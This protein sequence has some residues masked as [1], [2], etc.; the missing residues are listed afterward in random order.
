MAFHNRSVIEE[1]IHHK[2]MLPK[3]QLQLCDYIL[4]N[5]Q[6]MGL[7]TVKEL[8]DNADVGISTVMRL[9]H[10]LG[11]HTFNDFRRDIFNESYPY[12]SKWTLRKSFTEETG[13]T[14]HHSTVV[15]IWKGSIDILEQS[16]DDELIVH[17]EKAVDVICQSSQ[18][19][20][21]GTRPYKSLALYLEQM[22]NEFYPKIKQLS[23]DT[24]T[25][26]DK[27]L[28]ADKEEALLVF[29]FE[30]Y[31]NRVV[32][33]AELA[34]R[35]GMKIILVTDYMACPIIQYA[36]V[37]L[38]VQTSK[39]QYSIVP[40]IVLIEALAVEMGKR[41]SKETISRMEKLE[42]TLLDNDV[43]YSY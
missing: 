24:E 5:H 25:L 18:L 32:K 11:Y 22:L 29:A 27:I 7:M 19:C 40:I 43:I 42:K 2:D 4:K 13:E 36:S 16:L 30:P 37:T 35:Q 14:E 21:L 3:K 12:D 8:A 9:I 34:Y 10:A 20:L 1:M 38:K 15:D 17:F 39:D 28:L 6:S 41:F 33:A 23:H 26:F 31:T